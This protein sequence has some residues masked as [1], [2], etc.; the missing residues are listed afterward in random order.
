MSAAEAVSV[1]LAFTYMVIAPWW[2]PA[3]MA[4]KADFRVVYPPVRIPDVA[5]TLIAGLTL[6]SHAPIDGNAA[7]LAVPE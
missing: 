7:L 2:V 6:Y 5:V 4:S 3:L 1:V